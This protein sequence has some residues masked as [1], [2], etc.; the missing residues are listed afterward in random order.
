[1]GTIGEIN[2]DDVM[3]LRLVCHFGG[4]GNT[5]G[6][7][8]VVHTI[9][10][11]N[12]RR[13][14]FRQLIESPL[15]VHSIGFHDD[16]RKACLAMI[17]VPFVTK[18][19]WQEHGAFGISSTNNQILAALEFPDFTS[20]ATT[21]PRVVGTTDLRIGSIGELERQIETAWA[22]LFVVVIVA[23]AIS[24][25]VFDLPTQFKELIETLHGIR[26]LIVLLKD[27]TG[28][29]QG[30]IRTWWIIRHIEIG[31]NRGD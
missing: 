31:K 30:R 20:V 12:V 11:H 28:L 22:T 25:S 17:F 24:S 19:A 8:P 6:R 9:R 14:V 27:S 15:L 26:S 2:Y 13:L 4:I 7:P 10:K 5:R 1:M 21:G 3:I 29:D 16:A 23:V 18:M